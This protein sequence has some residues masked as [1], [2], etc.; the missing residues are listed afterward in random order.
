M[1]NI[2]LVIVILLIGYNV[3]SQ[4]KIVS[5]GLSQQLDSICKV[6]N[7]KLCSVYFRTGG[8]DKDNNKFDSKNTSF[9]FSDSFLI[10]N[11]VTFYNLDKLIYFK[12]E[13]KS[14]NPNKKLIELFFQGF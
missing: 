14:N 7:I 8:E 10:I 4:D 13:I 6:N 11:D 1:K 9:K 5:K 12:L 3:Y 2:I